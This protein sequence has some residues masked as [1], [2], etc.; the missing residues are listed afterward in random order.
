MSF[1]FS[2]SPYLKVMFVKMLV[3]QLVAPCCL[4]DDKQI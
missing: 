1:A 2:L 3:K 4:K